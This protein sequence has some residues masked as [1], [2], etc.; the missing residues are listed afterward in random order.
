MPV[1]EALNRTFI[2]T[3]VEAEHKY[4]V[5]VIDGVVYA[6][7]APTSKHQRIAGN[8]YAFLMFQLMGHP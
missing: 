1:S 4:L 3:P 8:M 2:D 7:S 6:M 5:E